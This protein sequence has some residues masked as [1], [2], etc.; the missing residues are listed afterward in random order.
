MSL[1]EQFNEFCQHR[2]S[3]DL[4]QEFM[5][6]GHGGLEASIALFRRYRDKL[7]YSIG[8]LEKMIDAQGHELKIVKKVG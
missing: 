6:A 7:P 3:Y 2:T 1:Q 5:L 8:L 4:G